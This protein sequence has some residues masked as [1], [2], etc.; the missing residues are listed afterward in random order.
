MLACQS[1]GA[2]NVSLSATLKAE[3]AF[4]CLEMLFLKLPK[5]AVLSMFEKCE[6]KT[7]L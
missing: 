6:E 2:L 1:F 5:D 3:N 7:F 4:N